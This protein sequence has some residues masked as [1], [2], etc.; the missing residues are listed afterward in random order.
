MHYE[1]K[2]TVMKNQAETCDL[3]IQLSWNR[4]TKFTGK[5]VSIAEEHF[6]AVS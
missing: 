4:I 1:V 6:E 3:E 2:F 5:R